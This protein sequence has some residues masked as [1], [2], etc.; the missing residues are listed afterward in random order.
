V[1]AQA[2]PSFIEGT[3]GYAVSIAL[4][5][6]NGAPWI[7]AI[8]DPVDHTLYHAIRG[9]GPQR[10]EQPWEVPP[11]PEGSV[12]SLFTDRGFADTPGSTFM[13]HRGVLFA[14]DP[15]LAGR[16]RALHAAMHRG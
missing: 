16:I 1:S 3:P 10:N 9:Q 5:A 8:Y 11:R 14:T 13:N 6:R 7:G 15:A 2:A 12:L 4:V